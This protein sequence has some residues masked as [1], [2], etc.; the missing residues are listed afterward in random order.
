MKLW[1]FFLIAFV[2]IAANAKP[3]CVIERFG[4]G[5]RTY[6]ASYMTGQQL[7]PPPGFKSHHRFVER[8][9]KF[10]LLVE[11]MES[12]NGEIQW[13][14]VFGGVNWPYPAS[15]SSGFNGFGFSMGMYAETETVGLYCRDLAMPFCQAKDTKHICES[16][17]FEGCHPGF[18]RC[19]K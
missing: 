14:H 4:V 1:V 8:F 13:S 2:S 18:N 6:Q 7:V 9:G 15:L 12:V 19:A 5:S 11:I 17:P 10:Q 3:E 16:I